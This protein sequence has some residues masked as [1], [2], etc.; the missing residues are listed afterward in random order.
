MV[1]QHF[2][3]FLKFGK[4]VNFGK[5]DK[6]YLLPFWTKLTIFWKF[7][8][9]YKYSQNGFNCLQRQASL[10]F[11]HFLIFLNFEKLANFNRISHDFGQNWRFLKILKLVYSNLLKMFIKTNVFGFSAFL[12]SYFK[13]W[14]NG[15]LAKLI[16]GTFK[17]GVNMLKM[18]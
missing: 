9:L 1:F 15:N 13:F 11:Q 3:K 8:R 10:V 14:K 17:D 2:R 5:N 16:G 18:A 7:Q 4:I 12:E 6:G